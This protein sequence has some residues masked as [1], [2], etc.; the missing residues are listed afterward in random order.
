MGN[1]ESPDNSNWISYTAEDDEGKTQAVG[2]SRIPEGGLTQDF[3]DC[4]RARI[5]SANS[6]TSRIVMEVKP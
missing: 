5:L 4:L 1:N 2:A 6:L 3:L